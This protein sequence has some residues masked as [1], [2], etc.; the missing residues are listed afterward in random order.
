MVTKYVIWA[1]GA[2]IAFN[3]LYDFIN[4]IGAN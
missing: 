2:L 3:W 1:I 4:A